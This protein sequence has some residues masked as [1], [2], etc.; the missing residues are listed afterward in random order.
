MAF[1]GIV[2]KAITNE[3]KNLI[4]Y[5][6]DKV[7]EPDKN[8]IILGLYGKGLNVN[9]LSCISSNNCR[10][11]IT[12][13]QFQNPPSAPSF[14]MSLRKHL[15]GMKIKDIYTKDLERVIFIDIETNDMFSKP[16]QKKLIIE[17]MGKHSNIILTDSN[18]IVINSMRHTFVE[19]NSNRDIYPSTKYNFPETQKK[20]FLQLKSFEEFYNLIEPAFTDYIIDN[21]QNI[22]D[23]SIF[24]FNLDKIISGVFNGIS[25]SF[26]NCL[27]VKLNLQYFSKESLLK[28][29]NKILE[30]LSFHK[31]NI[32]FNNLTNDYFLYPDN[33]NDNQ[34]YPIC[35]VLDDYYYN[36]EQSDL[37]KN[38]KNTLLNYILSILKKYEKR[39][40]NIDS[41]LSECNNIDKY[42]LYGELI[43]ANLY[44]IPNYNIKAIKLEN[45]YDNYKEITINLNDRFTPS[46][47]A[48]LFFKKYSKL[49]NAKSIVN[50]QKAE[51]I[52]EI[53]Y[54][55][56][57]IYELNSCQSLDDIS[58]IY[59]EISE[60]SIFSDISGKKIN[61]KLSRKTPKSKLLTKNKNTKFNP[62]KY[63]IDGYTILVGRNNFENDYLT[64]KYAK[65]ID[66][67]FH[68]KDTPGSHVILK[69]NL[70]E[71]IPDNIIFE[72][73]QIAAKHSK[74]KNSSHTPVDYCT[75][76]NVKKPHG[77]KPGY[78]IYRNNKTMFV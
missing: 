76:S 55:E 38:Y 15:I 16:I 70:N 11:H 74:A 45:Y 2:T 42:K 44:K 75:I 18:N 8:T 67:W 56:S 12:T 6:I 47:N 21:N 73:A 59:D 5:K 19:K 20:S 66:I 65:K 46:Y 68:T 17:L 54:L 4:G 60:N 43:T 10:I 29:Y 37:F 7:F 52:D 53:N 49:K 27:I 1:D 40:I 35:S 32:L 25:S 51:T 33:N 9:L 31:L 69:V 23:L 24:N 13:H 71:V 77:S 3:L 57:V 64:C 62:I 28:L 63:I 36:K 58:E 26:I 72:A 41:K 22:S 14:C 39:L 48:K 78:V 50:I 30:I 61:S 34:E